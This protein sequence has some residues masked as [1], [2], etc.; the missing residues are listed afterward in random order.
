MFKK[1]CVFFWFCA[2]STTYKPVE[3]IFLL[4]NSSFVFKIKL[5][6]FFCFV[7]LPGSKESRDFFA[8]KEDGWDTI[9]RGTH[10]VPEKICGAVQSWFVEQYT[11]WINI[12]MEKSRLWPFNEARYVAFACISARHMLN[13]DAKCHCK[14]H[15]IVVF[16]FILSKTRVSKH[17]NK[18]TSIS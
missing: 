6:F 13:W 15:K 14:W 2:I 5:W 3:S 10:P 17:E 8:P 4:K 11:S 18:A 12:V 16:K 9:A 1:S 7:F